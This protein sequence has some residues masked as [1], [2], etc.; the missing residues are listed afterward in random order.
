MKKT[1]TL[2]SS[3][4]LSLLA[5]ISSAQTLA[6]SAFPAAGST[7]SLTLCDTNVAPGIGGIGTTWNFASLT[8]AD[9]TQADMFMTPASTP[10][11]SLFPTADIAVHETI[12]TSTN[13]YIYYKNTGSCYQRIANVQPDTVTYSDPANEYP[14][15][16]SEGST[17]SDTYYAA[18]DATIMSGGLSVFSDGSGTLTLPTGTY[19][20]VIRFIATRVEHDT[21]GGLEVVLTQQFYNWYQTD[22]YY[23]ILSISTT[24]INYG[25][26]SFNKKSVGYRAGSTTGVAQVNKN[27]GFTIFP[28]PATDEIQLTVADVAPRS[29][30]VMSITGASCIN[31]TM[32][33]NTTSINISALPNG[34]YIV[35]TSMGEQQKIVVSH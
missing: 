6:G 24:N 23:P 27:N 28:N 31:T 29:V 21:V 8:S 20:N 2:F 18:Y 19:T 17:F 32:T 33:G 3:I 4:A 1:F 7:F 15:P 13:Y 34:M 30:E 26:G 9:S 10:Y 22:V 25:A 16:L 5:F 11:G 12:G 35:K 14:Y